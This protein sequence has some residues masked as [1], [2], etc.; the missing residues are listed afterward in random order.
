M[1]G[2]FFNVLYSL[3]MSVDV[4]SVIA[5]ALLV[6]FNFLNMEW[7]SLFY[8]PGIIANAFLFFPFGKKFL[9]ACC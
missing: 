6:P 7:M 2:V 1:L 5:K 4:F 3:L 9:V 8:V